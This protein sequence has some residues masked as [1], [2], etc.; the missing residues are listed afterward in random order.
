MSEHQIANA[1]T[2]AYAVAALF[3]LLLLLAVR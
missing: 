2:S 3:G 1:R